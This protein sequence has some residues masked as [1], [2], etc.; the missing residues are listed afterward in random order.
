M[1]IVIIVDLIKNL[2]LSG[3][4]IIYILERFNLVCERMLYVGDSIFD[5]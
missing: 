3:E 5:M 2:K 1:L 4:L